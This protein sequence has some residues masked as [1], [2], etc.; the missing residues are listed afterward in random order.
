MFG[1]DIGVNEGTPVHLPQGNWKVESVYN[2]ARGK[3]YI[4]NGENSG[5]GN[6]VLARNLDTGEAYRFSHLLKAAVQ[7]G[8]QH[9]RHRLAELSDEAEV[10]YKCTT[11]WH[12][13]SDRSLL[14]N[15]P[16]PCSVTRFEDGSVAVL[17]PAACDWER[18]TATD[19]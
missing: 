5:Y 18:D 1:I 19:H 4:G 14:W 16:D 2:N 10:L 9:Q 3:G 17:N 8:Q 12:Q 15:D 11:L 6:S 7:A 13:P